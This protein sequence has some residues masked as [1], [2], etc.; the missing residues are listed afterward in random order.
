[1]KFS[2]ILLALMIVVG[3]GFNV[4]IGKMGVAELNPL[5]FLAIR[6]FITGIIFLPF[7]KTTKA[8]LPYLF[9]I[10]LCLNVGHMGGVFVALHYLPATSIAVLQPLQVPLSIILSHFIL[11]EQISL[12][13]IAGIILAFCGLLSMFGVPDLSLP[14]LIA[15]ALG[16]FF[17]AIT[18]LIFKCSPQFNGCSFLAYT[19]L[20]ATPFLALASILFEKSNYQNFSFDFSNRFYFSLFFQVFA[21]SIAMLVW[22]RLVAKVGVSKTSPF[23]LLQIVFGIIGGMLIFNEKLDFNTILG[24][25]LIMAGVG[26]NVVSFKNSKK[27]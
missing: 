16:C 11:K 19:S 8:Q 15:L 23:A 18:Q 26:L 2:D 10:A 9:I 17:W 14:G 22:Q 25:I 7:A 5:L 24:A 20:I 6:F 4:A 13:Q 21:M 12:K 27:S 3:W 1:M